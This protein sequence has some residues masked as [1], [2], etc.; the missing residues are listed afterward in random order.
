MAWAVPTFSCSNRADEAPALRA[1]GVSR[2]SRCSAA[3]A[4]CDAR[5]ALAHRR[6]RLASCCLRVAGGVIVALM[7]TG[8]TFMPG[9]VAADHAPRHLHRRL[10]ARRSSAAAI[11][12]LDHARAPRRA[13]RRVT[14]RARALLSA[15]RAHSAGSAQRCNVSSEA[16]AALTRARLTPRDDRAALGGRLSRDQLVFMTRTDIRLA[17]AAEARRASAARRRDDDRRRDAPGRTDS[18]IGARG[19]A[20]RSAEAPV[21]GINSATATSRAAG[22]SVG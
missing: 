13:S 6:I 9:D 12:A 3:R 10:S 15:A 1:A 8:A 17:G 11:T 2:R 7:A 16:V 5:P 18:A 4:F 20:V 22:V 21:R 14:L 19:L